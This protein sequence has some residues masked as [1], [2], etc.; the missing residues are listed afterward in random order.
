MCGCA[1]AGVRFRYSFNTLKLC[2]MYCPAF[3]ASQLRG[4]GRAALMGCVVGKGL[5]D[6]AEA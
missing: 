5:L 1:T 3:V 4:E 2:E 6:F